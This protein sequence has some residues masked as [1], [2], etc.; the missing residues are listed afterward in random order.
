MERADSPDVQVVMEP[1]AMASSRLSSAASISSFVVSLPV[2]WN[3]MVHLRPNSLFATFFLAF[4]RVVARCGWVQTILLTSAACGFILVL[5]S[6]LNLI[7][8]GGLHRTCGRGR[9][10]P[11]GPFWYCTAE[12]PWG[13]LGKTRWLRMD[14]TMEDQGLQ[15]IPERRARD[16]R[17]DRIAFSVSVLIH[18]LIFGFWKTVPIPPSPFA[19]AGPRAGDSRPAAGGLRR[20]A[21]RLQG[22]HQ[23]LN[24]LK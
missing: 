18:V 12:K 23:H 10:T 4:L 13:G 17:V 8:P 5:A 16:R 7:F 2:R 11:G 9:E 6:S 19:A 22:F 14:P 1:T 20:N 24:T 21:P 3:S 15:S